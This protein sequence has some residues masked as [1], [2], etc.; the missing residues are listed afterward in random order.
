MNLR[1]RVTRFLAKP[2]PRLEHV[3]HR[4]TCARSGCYFAG[5]ELAYDADQ[6]P[7]WYCSGDLAD[8]V[9]RG[10]LTLDAPN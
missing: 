8:G 3:K 6:R 5:Y 10:W 9:R 2:A 7:G 4:P 1:D